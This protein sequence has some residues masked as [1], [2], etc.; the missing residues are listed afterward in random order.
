MFICPLHVIKSDM[1]GMGIIDYASKTRNK[2]LPG[3]THVLGLV[4]LY[5]TQ[6][7]HRKP[8]SANT[9]SSGPG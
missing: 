2:S 1:E 8:D 6:L 9:L 7:S 3:L 4:I 5:N